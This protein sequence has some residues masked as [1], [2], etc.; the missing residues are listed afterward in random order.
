MSRIELST[1]I[2]ARIERCFDLS[3]DI[4]AHVASM[5]FHRERA[6]AGVTSGLINLG[7]EVTW[8]AQHL[9]FRWRITSRITEFERPARFVDEMRRGPF[10]SF[11]HE[12]LFTTDGTATTMRDVVDY[13]LPLGPLG[14]AAD[15]VFARRYVRHLLQVRNTYLKRTAEAG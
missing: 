9:G 2:E 10:R 5:E 1:W 8:E 14:L 11:R 13:V 6:I 15:K 7:E 4:D 12:H 3:R